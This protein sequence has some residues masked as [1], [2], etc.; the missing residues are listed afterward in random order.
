MSL[1][2]ESSVCL[3]G[4]TYKLIKSKP[5]EGDGFILTEEIPNQITEPLFMT[6]EMLSDPLRFKALYL[7]TKPSKQ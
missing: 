2:N 3:E 1:P 6:R 4:I 5:T 7:L